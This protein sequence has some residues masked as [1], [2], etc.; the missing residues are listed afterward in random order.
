MTMLHIPRLTGVTFESGL[1][2]VCVQRIRSEY[3]KSH[4]VDKQI[5]WG[6][7]PLLPGI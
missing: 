3:Q 2:F 6:C 4:S 7:R 5:Q 1:L